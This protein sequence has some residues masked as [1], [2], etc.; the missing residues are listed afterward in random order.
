M[1]T[2]ASIKCYSCKSKFEETF[3][4][5]N[6]KFERIN[7]CPNCLDVNHIE[8]IKCDSCRCWRLDSE[9]KNDQF[10][11]RNKTCIICA[12]RHQNQRQ[13][14]EEVSRKKCI[15]GNDRCSCISCKNE[16][17]GGTSLCIHFIQKNKCVDCLGSGICGHFA[18]R[19]KCILCKEDATKSGSVEL[20]QDSPLKKEKVEKIP[21]KRPNCHINRINE[22]ARGMGLELVDPSKYLNACEKVEWKCLTCDGIINRAWKYIQPKQFCCIDGK[23]SY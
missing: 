1:E 12:N 16:G 15:H 8:K 19:T 22:Q 11:R 14:R 6:E 2:V 10:H 21:V 7:S 9:Y 5:L 4:E 20:K 18:L 3:R 17:I 23:H 13:N